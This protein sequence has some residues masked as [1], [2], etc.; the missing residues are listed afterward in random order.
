MT[1]LRNRL[2]LKLNLLTAAESDGTQ[3][4]QEISD[5]AIIDLFTVNSS[6]EDDQIHQLAADHG[7]TPDEFENRIYRLF[8]EVLNMRGP[9]ESSLETAVVKSL[10]HYEFFT[11]TGEG[12]TIRN[13]KGRPLTLNK[14]EQFGVRRSVNGRDIR[15][16]TEDD[17]PTIIF[18]LDW[19]TAV[20]LGKKC[21][22]VPAA[23][24]KR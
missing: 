4:L 15:L 18:S 12:L 13:A 22:P 20:F 19:D 7:L 2:Q 23:K 21:V 5:K 8:H 10:D 1:N 6:P 11:F 17:G 24:N 3:E 9:V 14:G 16:V